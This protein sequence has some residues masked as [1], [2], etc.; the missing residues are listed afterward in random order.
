MA[1]GEKR[2][3][4]GASSGGSGRGSFFV[5]LSA[6]YAAI[7]LVAG[8]HMPFLPVWLDWRGLS[9]AEIS[10]IFSAPYFIRLI[11]TPSVAFLADRLGN[12]R[13]VVIGLAWGALL[14]LG[15][16]AMQRSFWP[17]LF[18]SMLFTLFWSTIMPLT[19]TVAMAGV[20]AAG[21]D[22]GR[23]RLWGSVS[24]IAASFGGGFIV[25]WKGPPAALGII[26]AGSAA[27]LAVAYLLPRPQLRA[28]LATPG[29]RL[30]L[31]DA[32]RLIRNPLFVL[33]LIAIGA[34]QASHAVFYLFGTL[35]WRAQGYSTGMAGVLWA[36]A[37]IAEI[38]VFAYSGWC[39]ARVGVLGL[40]LLGA[41][42]GILRWTLMA[43]DPPLAVQLALQL[44]HAFTYG[45]AH[46]GAI[47]FI[48]R[49]VP[50]AQAGTAQALY[51]TVTSGVAMGLAMAGSGPL[52][53]GYGGG[54][55]LLMAALAVVALVTTW[56]LRKRW[57]GGVLLR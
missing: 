27:T 40:L 3:A 33:F 53:A 55:Y 36:V 13:G 24:F 16:M 47:H 35:H 41:G 50:D 56:L 10:T 18:A 15:A 8:T 30:S 32:M 57:D 5:R 34:E 14:S 4:A 11:V 46:L 29:P 26:M 31:A 28:E 2:Q 21:L 52:Y 42:A 12:H 49:A 6:F 23:M 51:A 44:L 45:A 19:E 9:A 37:V 25:D 1:A 17:I 38:G 48:A 43:F 7:F 54:A 39:V 20:R 22:Y